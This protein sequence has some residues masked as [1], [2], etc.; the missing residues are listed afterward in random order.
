[1]P[2]FGD[3]SHVPPTAEPDEREGNCLRTPKILRFEAMRVPC[4]Q[5]QS[6]GGRRQQLTVSDGE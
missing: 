5:L 3:R 2:R 6:R 4:R 1:M